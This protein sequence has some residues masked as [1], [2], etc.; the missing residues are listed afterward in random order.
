MKKLCSWWIP[1]NYTEALTDRVTWCY[2]I[3]I[4]FKLGALNLVWDIR[5][6]KLQTFKYISLDSE[7]WPAELFSWAGG[8][9]AS[10]QSGSAADGGCGVLLRTLSREARLSF[11]SAACANV[12]VKKLRKCGNVGGHL[13]TFALR[14]RCEREGHRLD[15]AW[16]TPPFASD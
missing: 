10:E 14:C 6:P 8:R 12:V 13:G 15:A 11:R 5:S 2:A 7:L 16:D 9:Q 1:H 3:L 4:R